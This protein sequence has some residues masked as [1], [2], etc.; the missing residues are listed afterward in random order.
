MSVFSTTAKNSMLDAL[1]PAHAVLHTGDPGADGTANRI[2]GDFST[3]KSCTF[4]AAASG[5]R[6]LSAAIDWTGLSS[7]QS[8]TWVSFWSD[9]AGSPDTFI[10]KAELTGDTAANTDGDFR[11]TTDTKLAINDPA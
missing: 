4:S 11:I 10:G 3:A 9:S 2:G 7:E 6:A 1:S 5:E 8:V